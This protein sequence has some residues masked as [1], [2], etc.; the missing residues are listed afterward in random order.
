MAGAR[1][2]RVGRRDA[3]APCASV[4][5]TINALNLAPFGASLFSM[6]ERAWFSRNDATN[7]TDQKS[8]AVFIYQILAQKQ[9]LPDGGP[10][11]RVYGSGDMQETGHWAGLPSIFLSGL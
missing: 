2:A 3:V 11:R 5:L 7:A 10:G 9:T 1:F 8:W 6:S 4:L